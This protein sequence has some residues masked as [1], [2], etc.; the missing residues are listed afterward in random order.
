[1]E[2]K[3]SLN[4]GFFIFWSLKNLIP[5]N[6]VHILLNKWWLDWL[7]EKMAKYLIF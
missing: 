7:V 5:I 2:G 4:R 6:Q 1:M 3:T